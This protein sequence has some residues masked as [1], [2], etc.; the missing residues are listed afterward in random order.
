MNLYEVAEISLNYKKLDDTVVDV[1]SSATVADVARQ[2]Y[3][4]ENGAI[5]HRESF[6]VLCLNARTQL[7]A[8]TL[9]MHGGVSVTLVDMKLLF[10]FAILHNASGIIV[11]H[12]HPSGGLTPSQQDKSLTR[13]IKDACAVLDINFLDHVIL[14]DKNHFSFAE[15]GYL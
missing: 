1:C 10:Q 14:T 15:E 5:N 2:C 3:D 11:F 6:G 13:K 8:R 12:N 4:Q 7:C 9:F